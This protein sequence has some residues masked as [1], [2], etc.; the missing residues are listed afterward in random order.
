MTTA[1]NVAVF[2]HRS[3]SCAATGS[4]PGTAIVAMP[5]PS[6][7]SVSVRKNDRSCSPAS[8]SAKKAGLIVTMPL[9][10]SVAAYSTPAGSVGVKSVSNRSYDVPF[11]VIDTV[12]S[13]L[14]EVTLN[15]MSVS[16]SP[17]VSLSWKPSP[18]MV[19]WG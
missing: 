17:I 6:P 1:R 2:A 5:V 3:K 19:G 8:L 9:L 10:A 16:R 15:R 13:S 4:R 11:T 12:A 7:L 18:A 14:T